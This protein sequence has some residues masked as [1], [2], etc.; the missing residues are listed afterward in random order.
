M[1][2][3]KAT[4]TLAYLCEGE[5]AQVLSEL[6]KRHPDLRGEANAIA[7]DLI[8]DASSDAVAEEVAD[9]VTGIGVDELGSRSGKHAWGYVEPGQAAW[10][11]LDESIEG[12]RDDMTRRCKAGM[13]P[14]A[15]KIC[16]GIVLGLHG[17]EDSNNDGV[18]GWVPDF[19][20]E[21]AAWAMS[22]LLDLYPQRQRRAAGNR[23]VRA[24]GEHVEDWGEMLNRVVDEAV[25]AKPGKWR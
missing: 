24:I 3:R 2:R 21:A 6:L 4:D 23:I 14:A 25:S 8:D 13:K 18:L 10:D 16:A 7:V 17:A 11:L 9:L 15:E 1:P 20:A 19:P 22:L 12:F 5:H